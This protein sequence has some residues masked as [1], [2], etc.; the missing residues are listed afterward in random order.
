MNRSSNVVRYY[1]TGLRFLFV[2]HA[3]H[4]ETKQFMSQF[5]VY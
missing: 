3:T 4:F 1:V 5:E 2:S